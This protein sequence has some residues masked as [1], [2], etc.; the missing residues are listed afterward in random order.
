M[1][2]ICCIM[3]TTNKTNAGTNGTLTE[4]IG[5]RYETGSSIA[6]ECRMETRSVR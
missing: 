3:F 6:E 5:G 2:Q 1:W 4:R